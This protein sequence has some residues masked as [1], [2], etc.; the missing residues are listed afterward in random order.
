M[1][2]IVSMLFLVCAILTA[3]AQEFQPSSGFIVAKKFRVTRPL[4]DLQGVPE[5]S[6]KEEE[7]RESKDRLKRQPQY[8]EFT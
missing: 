5:K 1:K 4:R 7:I 3:G 8:F 2:T 6:N